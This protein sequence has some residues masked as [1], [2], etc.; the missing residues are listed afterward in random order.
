MNSYQNFI[1]F[2]TDAIFNSHVSF[3][4]VGGK[5]LVVDPNFDPARHMRTY[6]EVVSIP[7]HLGTHPITQETKGTP[8][9]PQ[10]PFEYRFMR[11]IEQDV[12]ISDKI[13]FHFN[14][15]RTGKPIKTEGT[16]PNK[17]FWFPC[18]Y[19]NVIC[20]VRDKEIIMIGSYV[21]CYPDMESWEDILVPIYSDIKDAE[22]NPILKPKD[23]WLQRKVRPEAKF[24][25]AFVKHVGKPLKGDTCEVEVGQRIWYRRNADWIN[26]VEGV[27]YFAI[28]QRHIIGKEVNGKFEPVRDYMLVI[29]EEE[30]EQTKSGIYIKKKLTSRGEV[31]HPGK[32]NFEKGLRVMFGYSD[33]QEL[34]L[35]GKKY[36]LIKKG[37]VFAT[38]TKAA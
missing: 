32:S 9:D 36:L 19:D 27:D 20:T 25:K 26:T 16:H 38:K 11:D 28:R 37:D 21:L 15:M 31:F 18:S 33:R 29:P 1:I 22:G 30:P 35:E 23:Q 12:R 14:V 8:P 5:E 2:K 24:L 6:G 7:L 34:E 4:G 10:K 3:K 17:T 13:Y